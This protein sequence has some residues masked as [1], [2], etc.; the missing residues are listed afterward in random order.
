MKTILAIAVSTT[1]IG[2]SASAQT[3][4][5]SS[6]ATEAFEVDP[7]VDVDKRTTKDR[8]HCGEV[9]MPEFKKVMGDEPIEGK[10]ESKRATKSPNLGCLELPR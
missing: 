10:G 7:D 8:E 3:K 9:Y 2:V 4:G 1:L 5:Q 6:R